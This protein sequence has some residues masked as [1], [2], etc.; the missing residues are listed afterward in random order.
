MARIKANPK[1]K[2]GEFDLPL[3]P[4]L[5]SPPPPAEIVVLRNL[6]RPVWTEQ[7]AKL[8]A[9]Y[10]RL[11]TYVT[12]HGTYID[13]FAGPQSERAQDG[14]AAELVLANSPRRLRRFYLCDN[15]PKQ[16]DALSALVARQP[17]PSKADSK[18]EIV[19]VPGD[20]NQE[21]GEILTRKLDP[22]TFCLLDQRTFECKWSTV[23]T[24]ANLRASGPKI[25]IFYFLP[26]GWIN[27]A[28]I[29]TT[30]NHSE[31]DDWWGRPDWQTLIDMQHHEKALAFQ[32][33]FVDLGYKFVHPFPIF[34][35]QNG[36][37]IMF[38]MIL[39]SDHPEAPKLMWRAY[40]QAVHD[41]AGWDQLSLLP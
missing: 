2:V 21:V 25:E 14:W 22:A 34:D 38:Y 6:R 36:D 5:P 29:A 7:K 8:I 35:H 26:M 19:I 28:I 4:G 18:R 13:G 15:D 10:L 9:R 32:K 17:P 16:R 33:R 3:F 11:F 31:I 41:V 27:R 1:S 24:L 40:D 39:A 12:R 30:K 37:R 23:V 20:F